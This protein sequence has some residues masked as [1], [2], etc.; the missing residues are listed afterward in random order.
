M[1]PIQAI[2]FDMGDTLVDLG[3][4]RGDYEARVI[5]RAGRVYDALAARGVRLPPRDHFCRELAHHSEARYQAAL[6]DLRGIAIYDVLSWFLPRVDV[7]ADDG[8]VR[9]AGEAFYQHGGGEGPPLRAGARDV[10]QALRDHGCRLGVISNTL[11]PGAIAQAGLARRGLLDFFHTCIYSS[12]VQAAKPHPA[13]FRAALEALGVR[14]ECTWH[15][16]DRLIADVQGAQSVGM[17]AVLIEVAHRSED[18][19]AD[20]VP[21]VRIQELPELLDALSFRVRT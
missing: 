12:E 11:Q 10:L 16:G 17:K 21:D 3:E 5:V 14:P 8:L 9:V 6:M 19:R 7:P 1:S 13:I 20:I 15:V 4:G 18:A 2:T